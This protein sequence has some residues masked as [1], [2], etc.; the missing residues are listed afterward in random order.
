MKDKEYIL[1]DLTIDELAIDIADDVNE[2][3]DC[4]IRY[5]DTIK[6]GAINHLIE[7][8]IERV[9]ALA[10]TPNII[11]PDDHPLHSSAY[12]IADKIHELD[13]VDYSLAEDA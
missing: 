9:R 8:E 11:L 10:S 13:L 4:E 5:G 3:V 12:D 2:T 1:Y 7:L 6:T